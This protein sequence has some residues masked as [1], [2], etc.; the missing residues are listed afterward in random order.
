MAGAWPDITRAGYVKGALSGA[1]SLAVKC[2]RMS[3]S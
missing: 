3:H 1:A 2:G